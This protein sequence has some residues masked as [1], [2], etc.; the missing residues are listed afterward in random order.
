MSHDIRTPLNAIMGFTDLLLKKERREHSKKYLKKIEMSGQAL[1]N[2]INDIL[3]F[4]KIEA[5]Q[6]DIYNTTFLVKKL[7]E[8]LH[9][10]FSLQ[11]KEKGIHFI[12][13]VANSVP[14]AI[15]NDMWRINQVLTN[16]L[17]N[18]LKFT[19]R[20]EVILSLEYNETNDLLV[21]HVIDTGIGIDPS[22]MELIFDP[23]YQIQSTK[24]GERKGTGLGL[25]IC[26]KLSLLMGGSLTVT[27]QKGKGT[28]FQVHIPAYSDKVVENNIKEEY[29]SEPE[30]L[31]EDKTGNT[32]LIAEDNIV[33]REL[34]KEQFHNAGFYFLIFTEDGEETVELALEQEPDLILMDVQMPIMDGNEA[35][36]I[37]K[38]N[39]YKGPII[40]LSALA[41]REDID[42]SLAAGADD[43]ITKPIDFPTFFAKISSYLKVKKNRPGKSE[44]RY[45]GRRIS[46]DIDLNI[47]G[48]FSENVKMVFI[49]EIKNKLNTIDDIFSSN[50]FQAKKNV[51]QKI[52]HGFRGN[53]GYFG[54]SSL[55][56]IAGQMDNAFIADS[57]EALMMELTK[58]LATVLEKIIEQNINDQNN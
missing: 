48:A 21:C 42:E 5:G 46:D 57:D 31:L 28:H 16:L 53:A 12:I 49:S 55:Q 4:S 2:L 25:S 22:D 33:N 38:K 19:D 44:F 50:E 32:I 52:A 40:T 36:R 47:K 11:F 54:L 1:L 34:I 26:K 10:M 39:N 35:I 6:L 56:S 18:A 13:K 51:L 23:F 20:G 15:F 27:S 58:T 14:L 24:M 7:T 17:S 29:S 3:D 8:N 45:K 41:M 37:L 30:S 43:F 9:T